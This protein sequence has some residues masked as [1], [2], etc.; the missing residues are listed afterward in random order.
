MGQLEARREM[1]PADLAFDAPGNL[2]NDLF[3]PV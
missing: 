1:A 3:L 2:E